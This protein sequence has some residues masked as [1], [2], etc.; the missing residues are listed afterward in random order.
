LHR[1]WPSGL[2]RQRGVVCVKQFVQVVG[3]PLSAPP[4]PARFDE[5]PLLLGLPGRLGATELKP[6]TDP[7]RSGGELG[8]DCAE[9]SKIPLCWPIRAALGVEEVR[10]IFCL[11]SFPF[12]R[13]SDTDAVEAWPLPS[14]PPEPSHSSGD[15]TMSVVVPPIVTCFLGGPPG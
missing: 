7:L 10:G 12:R 9:R 2:R 4:A 6:L 1:G 15:D 5:D 11:R 8:V 14:E 13:L 3:M